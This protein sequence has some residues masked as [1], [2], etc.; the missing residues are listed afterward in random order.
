MNS[1]S[2]SRA[3]LNF[4]LILTLLGNLLAPTLAAQAGSATSLN[5][6]VVCD[7]PDDYDSAGG[8]LVKGTVTLQVVAKSPVAVKISLLPVSD[9]WKAELLTPT[10]T[11]GQPIQVRFTA[12]LHLGSG[13]MSTA[14]LS[15]PIFKVRFPLVRK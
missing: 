12:P 8:F 6:L 2:S 10:A 13:L 11:V 7:N 3:I 1:H 4:F 5:P 9:S 14:D 15:D